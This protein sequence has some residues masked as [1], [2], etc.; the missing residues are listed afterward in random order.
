[1]LSVSI[2][3]VTWNGKQLLETYLPSV[4]AHSGNA[5][6]IIADNASQDD[7]GSWLAQTFPTV[8][9]CLLD[10]NYGYCG[11]NNKAAAT[12]NGDILLFLNNDVEVTP[13]WL[14]PIITYFE[15]HPNTAALQPKIR[16]W[17]NKVMF[18]YAGAAGG[19]LDNLGFPFCRGRV[20]DYLEQDN[21]QYDHSAPL[22]W[23]SGAAFAI[24][25]ELFFTMGQFDERFEFHMEEIDLCWRL[26][27][28]GY[29]VHCVTDS[30]VFHLGGASLHTGSPQ[31]I[32]YNFRNSLFLLLKN[33]PK[34]KAFSRIFLRLCLDG[35][36]GIRAL[37]H[38]RPLE[39]LAIIRAHFGF[40]RRLLGMLQTRS[41]LL[42]TR[43]V[44]ENPK[45]IRAY[46]V[47]WRYFIKGQKTFSQLE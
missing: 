20:F 17:N 13:N 27:I 11:G 31:K 4:V 29:D 43:T 21:G 33:L 15:K 22:A 36:A 44:K 6:I 10:D 14:N 42:K 38:L 9:H 34:G 7:T 37:F 12:A 5:E 40:Y 3:I 26:L 45:E 47:V 28:H 35:I 18:E 30:V 25:K 2:I 46:S 32:Y 16:D 8:R 39:T 23:V 19:L 41:I 1:M 24:R